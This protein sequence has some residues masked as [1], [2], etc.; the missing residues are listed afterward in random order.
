MPLQNRVTP[1]GE[2]VSYEARGQLMGNR[3]ILHDD[4]RRLGKAR[5]RHPHWIICR[6]E[7][8]GR[9]DDV[10]RPGAYTRLFFLDDAVALAAGHRPCAFCRRAAYEAF[11]AAWIGG[12]AHSIRP[13]AGA[14]DRQLQRERVEPRTRRQIT[15][16]APID[17]LPDGTFLTLPGELDRALLLLGERLLPWTPH[18]YLPGRVRPAGIEV[19]TLTPRSTVAALRAGFRPELHPSTER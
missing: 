10:M 13:R 5:W 2:I 8:K 4:H 18:G 12:T 3:G 7:F 14:I 9:R 6:L 15:H 16:L 1:F 19:R 11:V 17:D